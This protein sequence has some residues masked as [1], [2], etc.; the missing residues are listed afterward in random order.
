[1]L[2]IDT[3]RM[4]VNSVMASARDHRVCAVV[5]RS[6]VRWG[7][8]RT[9]PARLAAAGYHVVIPEDSHGRLMYGRAPCF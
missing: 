2:R 8:F 3:G 5:V 7:S 1:V 6:V 9:L 4:D